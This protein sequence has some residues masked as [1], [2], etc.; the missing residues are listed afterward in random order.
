MVR[1]SG[2]R[3][4]PGALSEDEEAA[5]RYA[6][7]L[8]SEIKLYNE[9]TVNDGRAKRDLGFR[10]KNEIARA[11]SLYEER[12]SESVRSRSP[13]F[14]QELVRTLGGGDPSLIGN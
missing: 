10:L 8:V 1:W 3:D 9:N 12:I 7:L 4:A 13:F 2:H 11:R 5:R 14:K 6:R